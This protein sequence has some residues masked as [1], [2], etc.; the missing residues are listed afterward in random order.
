MTVLEPMPERSGLRRW[1]RR[2]AFVA[3]AV[4]LTF[5]FAVSLSAI[6]STEG[7]VRP[8]GQAAA[9][10]ARQATQGDA[11]ADHRDCPHRGGRSRGASRRV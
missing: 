4:A 7:T 1:L 6:A 10:A 5:A 9:I 2:V 8:D 11:A 3:S